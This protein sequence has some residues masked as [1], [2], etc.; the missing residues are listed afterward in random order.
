LNEGFGEGFKVGFSVGLALRNVEIKKSRVRINEHAKLNN[1]PWL[2]S[3]TP[4]N[5]KA[6][7]AKQYKPCQKARR[8]QH[9][10]NKLSEKLFDSNSI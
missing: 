10:N 5:F 8:F 3:S 9:G 2:R 7:N 4:C 1:L 6:T